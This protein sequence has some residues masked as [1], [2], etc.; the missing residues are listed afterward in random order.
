MKIKWNIY[1]RKN[2]TKGKTH[3]RWIINQCSNTATLF[4]NRLCIREKSQRKN[5][6][7]KSQN[8]T[9]YSSILFHN[10]YILYFHLNFSLP[11]YYISVLVDGS[12]HRT[13]VHIEGNFILF[14]FP[15]FSTIHTMHDDVMMLIS[16]SVY[17]VWFNSLLYTKCSSIS[18]VYYIYVS[19]FI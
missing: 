4:A 17:L 9:A 15:S 6:W 12:F 16:S 8:Q 14:I 10:L 18:E 5:K 19:T 11:S 1:Y 7:K 2:I 3:S 13:Y